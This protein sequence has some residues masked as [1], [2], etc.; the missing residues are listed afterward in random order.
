MTE[1]QLQKFIGSKI[2][3][4]REEKKLTQEDVAR[5]LDTTRQT[6]SRYE[7]GGRGANQDVLFT[8][9]NL[10]NK[11]VDDFFPQRKTYSDENTSKKKE[12]KNI[13]T[14]AAHLEGKNITDDKMKDVLNYI[15]FIFRDQFDK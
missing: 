11:K 7:S 8:L 12:D 14:I 2:K 10:F 4:F 9:A 1:V 3:Q 6:I 13:K 5:A 15:D